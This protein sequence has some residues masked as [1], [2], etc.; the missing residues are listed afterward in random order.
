MSR[1]GY[2][3]SGDLKSFDYAPLASFCLRGKGA[4]TKL[5]KFPETKWLPRDKGE[6]E[7]W[8]GQSKYCLKNQY[9]LLSALQ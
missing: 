4:Q 8:Y 5:F 7:G 1:G 9:M 3:V 2:Y 6:L